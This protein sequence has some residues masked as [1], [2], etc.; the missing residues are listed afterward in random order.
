[1]DYPEVHI[2]DN[3]NIKHGYLPTFELLNPSNKIQLS[4]KGI[5]LLAPSMKKAM[6]TVLKI[7]NTPY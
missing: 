1:M 2:S 5:S 4:P 3:E 6:H 7:G